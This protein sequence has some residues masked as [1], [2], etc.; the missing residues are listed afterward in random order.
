MKKNTILRTTLS[1]NVISIIVKICKP[2]VKVLLCM[3]TC[4]SIGLHYCG[5]PGNIFQSLQRQG[6]LST[7]IE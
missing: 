3:P 6:D 1:W 4:E 5:L 2:V 7:S